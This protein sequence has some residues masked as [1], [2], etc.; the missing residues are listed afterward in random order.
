MHGKTLVVVPYAKGDSN[1]IL[2]PV[3][4]PFCL[5]STHCFWCCL[6]ASCPVAVCFCS[7]LSMPAFVSVSPCSRCMINET[8][9]GRHANTVLA[10][11][12]DLHAVVDAELH[13]VC[14]VIH[15]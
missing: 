3:P 9:H 10:S 6:F 14:A 8:E 15:S 4:D 5:I 13:S 1:Q 2:T 7:A 12:V 11:I